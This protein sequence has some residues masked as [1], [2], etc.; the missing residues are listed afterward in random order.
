MHISRVTTSLHNFLDMVT[1]LQ[2]YEQPTFMFGC[3]DSPV[4]G[5]NPALGEALLQFTASDQSTAAVRHRHAAPTADG[6][7]H[8]FMFGVHPE[9]HAL[10]PL[11][12]FGMF[13]REMELS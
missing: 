8:A 6:S 9:Q 1:W 4:L 10:P 5:S 3:F 7:E 11:S 13:L 2:P 12:Q